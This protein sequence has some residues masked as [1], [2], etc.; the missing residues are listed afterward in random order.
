[1][2][3]NTSQIEH[4]I[5]AERVELGRNLDELE[6]RAKDLANWRVH[7]R[8]HSAA[9]LGAAVSVGV[10]FGVLSAGATSPR[11]RR[12]AGLTGEAIPPAP[13]P[14]SLPRARNP[15]VAELVG[16]WQRISEAL[17]GVAISKVIDVVSDAIPGFRHQ[18]EGRPE[19]AAYAGP[20]DSVTRMYRDELGRNDQ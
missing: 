16:T 9:F 12:V 1:V 10:L 15:K 20:S 11:P 7:Y 13:R 14:V 8:N 5:V 2:G 4:E 17:L 18:Y 19:R 3:E 6:Q